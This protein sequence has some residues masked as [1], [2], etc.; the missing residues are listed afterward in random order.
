MTFDS[1]T[2]TLQNASPGSRTR[3]MT[4]IHESRGNVFVMRFVIHDQVDED[5]LGNFTSVR[6]VISTEAEG[7][8]LYIADSVSDERGEGLKYMPSS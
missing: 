4:S 2:E 3:P 8:G 1:G 6:D 7:G 5:S